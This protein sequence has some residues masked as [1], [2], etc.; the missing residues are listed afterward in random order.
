MIK[1]KD[2]LNIFLYILL[3]IFSVYI[4]YQ[5]ILKIFGGS[6]QTE[7][8]VIALLI[9]IIGSVLNITIKLAKLETNFSNLKTSFCSLAKDF[10]EHLSKHK[11]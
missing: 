6:W 11:T 4:I 3:I 9:L 7:D 8:I 2:V 1:T 5:L 10:K